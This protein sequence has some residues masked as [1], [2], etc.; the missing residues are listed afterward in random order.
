MLQL[1]DAYIRLME[2]IEEC[3]SYVNRNGGFI[4][5]GQYK[6]GVINN[7]ILVAGAGNTSHHNNDDKVQI[8]TGKISYHIVQMIPTNRIFLQSGS[9]LY[10]GLNQRKF[11]ANEIEEPN[12]E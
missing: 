9:P 3:I 8:E 10:I 11:N 1:T 7:K 4:I 6:Q 5:V 2:F 12:D